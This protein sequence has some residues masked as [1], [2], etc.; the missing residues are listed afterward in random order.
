M[1]LELLDNKIHDLRVQIATTQA[2][3][4]DLEA[5]QSPLESATQMLR[6]D[7]T[8]I[9]RE[10]TGTTQQLSALEV[11][12]EDLKNG[13]NDNVERLMALEQDERIPQ[14]M[15]LIPKTDEMEA[16]SRESTDD[17]NDKIGIIVKKVISSWSCVKTEKFLHAN[18]VHVHRFQYV[19]LS[20]HNTKINV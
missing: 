1:R 19:H 4:D 7:V 5:R 8:A 13:H 20:M 6:A 3:L 14:L 16:K 15:G 2:H 18:S 10:L 11:A 17:I 9:E 12:V